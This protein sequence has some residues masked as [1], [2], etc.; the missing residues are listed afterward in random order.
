M[1]DDD[2]ND[3]NDGRWSM[4][5]GSG[6]QKCWSRQVLTFQKDKTARSAFQNEEKQVL[7]FQNAGKDK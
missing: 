7:A 6:E 3:D 2:N 1:D 5:F 4:A